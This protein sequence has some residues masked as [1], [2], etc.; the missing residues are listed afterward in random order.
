[1]DEVWVSARCSTVSF[2]HPG[3]WLR[4]PGGP[5]AS[6]ALDPPRPDAGFR[7]NL[8][9]T[10][11]DNGNLSFRDWQAGTDRILPIL[12]TDYQV[13]DLQRLGVAGHPGGRR[14]AYHRAPC[15]RM[16]LMKQWFT[17]VKGFGVTLTATA[18][19]CSSGLLTATFEKAASTLSINPP[20]AHRNA[21][22]G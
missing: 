7:A 11:A 12:L 1:M 17:S 5:A 3:S 15:G 14:S 21:R 9:L 6:A 2:S 19:L 4:A 10:V 20:A 18:D 8:V 13:I 16:V 22:A